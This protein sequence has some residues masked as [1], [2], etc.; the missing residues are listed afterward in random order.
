MFNQTFRHQ[1]RNYESRGLVIRPLPSYRHVLDDLKSRMVAYHCRLSRECFLLQS[2]IV[3]NNNSPFCGVQLQTVSSS[4]KYTTIINYQ[5]VEGGSQ[6]LQYSLLSER[7]LL[8]FVHGIFILLGFI[9]FLRVYRL[10]QVC[11]TQCHFFQLA[12]QSE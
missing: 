6:N 1:N 8:I 9:F 4:R 7:K 3:D 5:L 10:N 12:L 11:H 2:K